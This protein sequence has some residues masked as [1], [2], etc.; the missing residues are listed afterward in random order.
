MAMKVRKRNI[1]CRSDPNRTSTSSELSRARGWR[2]L[3]LPCSSNKANRRKDAFA[4][5]SGIHQGMA[6]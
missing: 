3:A 1:I 4:H 5:E 2:C 6:C